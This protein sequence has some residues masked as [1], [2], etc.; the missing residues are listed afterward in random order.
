MDA[1][2]AAHEELARRV[3]Q[4]D[5]MQLHGAR[6]LELQAMVDGFITADRQFLQLPGGMKRSGV[7]LLV[8]ADAVGRH[9]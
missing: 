4:A 7:R 8:C 3:A 1:A 5:I 9:G 2:A 6:I